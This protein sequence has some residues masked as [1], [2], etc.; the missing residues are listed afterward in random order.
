MTAIREELVVRGSLRWATRRSGAT[1]AGPRVAI[2][3]ER[4]WG[5]GAERRS[6]QAG[7]S[8]PST[9]QAQAALARRRSRNSASL[10]ESST[11]GLAPDLRLEAIDEGPGELV[12]DERE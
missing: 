4:A 8:R 12:R 9:N 5:S 3:N 1:P 7:P 11:T 10:E 2:R 6:C